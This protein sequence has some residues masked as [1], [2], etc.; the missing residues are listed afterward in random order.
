MHVR[1]GIMITTAIHFGM[2]IEIHTNMF[3]AIL[4]LNEMLSKRTAVIIYVPSHCRCTLIW[5][6]LPVTGLQR[7]MDWFESADTLSRSN[8]V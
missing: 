7:T 3:L 6:D 4:E 2:R 5:W 8:T 1:K